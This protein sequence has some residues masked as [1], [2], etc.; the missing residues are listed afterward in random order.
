MNDQRDPGDLY[1]QLPSSLL[2]PKRGYVA[3]RPYYATYLGSTIAALQA[4]IAGGGTALTDMTAQRDTWQSRANTAYD[5]GVWGSGTAWQTDY[6]NEV[7]AFN[8]RVAAD[9]VAQ[10]AAVAAVTTVGPITL[11][12]SFQSVVLPFNVVTAA[13][14]TPALATDRAGLWWIFAAINVGSQPL[15]ITCNIGSTVASGTISNNWTFLW[16]APVALNNTQPITFQLYTPQAGGFTFGG[17]G[18]ISVGF[19]PTPAQPH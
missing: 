2:V 10:A 15:S 3:K 12:A 17:G 5:S 4:Q 8:A 1:A 14:I 16:H 18:T 11:N 6:N 19:V 13:P 9:A 7:A